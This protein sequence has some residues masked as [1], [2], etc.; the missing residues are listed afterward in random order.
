VAV[1]TK[2]SPASTIPLALLSK[3]K[4]TAVI[5]VVKFP[6]PEAVKVTVVILA[7]LFPGLLSWNC[8]TGTVTPT[9]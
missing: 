2:V 4:F 1:P 8:N 9:S 5:P 7:V 3:Y 6:V